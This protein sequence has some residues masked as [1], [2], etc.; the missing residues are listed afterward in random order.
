MYTN[1]HYLRI[2]SKI[3]NTNNNYNNSI[4][5]NVNDNGV[6]FSFIYK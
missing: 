1:G 2:I 3:L 6:C 4:A 5:I